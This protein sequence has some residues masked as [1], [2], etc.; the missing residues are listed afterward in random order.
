MYIFIQYTRKNKHWFLSYLDRYEI[1]SVNDQSSDE[2]YQCCQV[3]AA[4][5]LYDRSLNPLEKIHIAM[6]YCNNIM[7][8]DSMALTA[9]ASQ[10]YLQNSLYESGKSSYV[11]K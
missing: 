1:N 7:I 9:I 10:S 2:K 8:V 5:L 4:Y 3:A 6:Y 11:K